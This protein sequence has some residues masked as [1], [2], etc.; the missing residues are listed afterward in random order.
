MQMNYTNWDIEIRTIFNSYRNK[1]TLT[2]DNIYNVL[3]EYVQRNNRFIDLRPI[4]YFYEEFYPKLIR[5]MSIKICDMDFRYNVYLKIKNVEIRDEIR[6][7]LM[8][9]SLYKN[10]KTIFT[11]K[12][13]VKIKF[14]KEHYS[15]IY[16]DSKDNFI[17]LLQNLTDKKV[18]YNNKYRFHDY[19]IT[20]SYNND[21]F[22]IACEFNEF[23]HTEEYDNNRSETSKIPLV[24][25]HV[26]KQGE[27]NNANIY[28]G[29][30]IKDIIY[31]SCALTNNNAFIAKMLMNEELDEE[32]YDRMVL[33]IDCI[34]NNRF[35]LTDIS[36][37]FLLQMVTDEDIV[38]FLNEN[39]LLNNTEEQNDKIT[40][41]IDKDNIYY[42]DN[43]QFEKLV[44]LFN[45]DLS[46]NYKEI[47]GIYIKGQKALLRATELLL[48]KE[49]DHKIDMKNISSF[50]S[51]I[52]SKPI[53]EIIEKINEENFEANQYKKIFDQLSFKNHT[54]NKPLPYIFYEDKSLVHENELLVIKKVL[55]SN[56]NRILKKT[57]EYLNTKEP[58]N[59]IDFFDETDELNNNLVLVNANINWKEFVN[60]HYWNTK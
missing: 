7:K 54:S 9:Y 31:K 11:D 14:E 15:D 44:L 55:G 52:T 21:A 27:T 42:L 22:Q 60:Y 50:I 6:Y 34:A 47:L 1:K 28:I 35:N 20:I 49:N 17:K 38:N 19:L 32:Q 13:N 41:Y 29:K 40:Y 26:R 2:R 4:V 51:D 48:Q 56:Y 3:L 43:E 12:F 33:L 30:I 46:Q 16:K 23:H 36:S 5:E 59:I 18:V 10:N 53:K 58:N 8:L 37:L 45:S 25:L 24:S 39:E 57:I